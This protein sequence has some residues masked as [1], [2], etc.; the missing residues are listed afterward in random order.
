MTNICCG[1]LYGCSYDEYDETGPT[2]C[3]QVF[4]SSFKTQ[5]LFS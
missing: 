3:L 2:S 4:F 1:M 5:A